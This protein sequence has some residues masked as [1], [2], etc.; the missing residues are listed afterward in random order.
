[1]NV[2]V[3]PFGFYIGVLPPYI[4]RSYVVIAPP[5]VV[6]VD[7]PVYAHD[8]YVAAYSGDD[9]YYLHRR[10]ED[11]QWRND[12]DLR[13]AVYDLEDAFR[14]GD[15]TLL[16]QH[17]NPGTK[18]AIFAKGSYEYSL[19][20][21]DYLDM[22]RDFMR[23]A[24]TTVF[25]VYRVHEK[26]DGVYQLFARHTYQDQ[27]NQSRTVYLC[28]VAQRMADRWVLTQIDTSPDQING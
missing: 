7:T 22:T 28:V 10:N 24:H 4:E 11:D 6:F 8:T 26:T 5:P 15:I 23:N 25:D 13:R 27:D 1:V 20:S 2:A 16:T 9:G 18:I 19:D 17:A 14:N 21:N 3:S 12:P